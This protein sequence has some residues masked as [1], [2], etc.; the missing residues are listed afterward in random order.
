MA[1]AIE[2][3]P[4]DF[5]AYDIR[6]L[7]YYQKGNFDQALSDINKAIELNPSESKSYVNRALIYSKKG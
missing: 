6:G 2:L 4:K 5:M 7:I 1:K 3:H